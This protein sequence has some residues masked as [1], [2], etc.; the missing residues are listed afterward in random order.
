MIHDLYV[1]IHVILNFFVIGSKLNFGMQTTDSLNQ[2]LRIVTLKALALFIS[3]FGILAK[4]FTLHKS[5][6]FEKLI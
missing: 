6:F 3:E 4:K 1:V 5:H 2:F